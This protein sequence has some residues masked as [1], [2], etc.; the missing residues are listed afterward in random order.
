[1]QE[2][3]D[4][5]M[6][7][8]GPVGLGSAAVCLETGNCTI[9]G[10]DADWFETAPEYKDV[11]LTS[12]LKKIDVSVYKTIE[13]TMNGQFTGGTAIYAMLDGGVD[14][15]PYHEYDSKVPA[16]LKAEVETV[17]QAIID[18]SVTVDGVLGIE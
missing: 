3:A 11:V 2:G 8:A 14:I 9:I 18:G 13:D 16:D 12:V 10:V 6:P 17:K 4:I 7:V 15:A 1:M 5:I